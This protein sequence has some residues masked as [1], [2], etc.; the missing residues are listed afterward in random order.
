MIF[1][2]AVAVKYLLFFLKDAW[3]VFNNPYQTIRGIS[4]KKQI[5]PILFF[6]F[7]VWISLGFIVGVRYGI[8]TG[9]L[10]LTFSLGKLFYAAGATFFVISL[11]MYLI[12]RMMGGRGDVLSVLSAWSYSYLPTIIWFF[13]TSI[14]YLVFPPPRT[15]SVLGQMLSILYLVVSLGLLS[16]KG[17]VYFLT[18]RF[19]LKLNLW[20][21]IRTTVV[22]WPFWFLYFLL[23]NRMGIFK[24]PFA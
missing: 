21:T 7:L 17:L 14:L 18:L 24:I 19:A 12:G 4:L 5:F 23:L 11:T 10:F 16:W 22:L 6:G 3:G 8:H 2:Y 20:Q 15:D 1:S 9:P 13:L